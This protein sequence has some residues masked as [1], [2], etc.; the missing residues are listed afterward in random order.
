MRIVFALVCLLVGATALADVGIGVSATENDSTI[1]VPITASRLMFEPYV[2]YSD[3]DAVFNSS[4]PTSGQVEEEFEN[5]EVGVGIFRPLQ[6]RDR[7]TFYYGGRVAYGQQRYEST[8]VDLFSGTGSPDL[9]MQRTDLD[10]YSIIPSLGL[11]YSVI[12]RLSLGVEV[13]WYYSELDGQQFIDPTFGPTSDRNQEV[14][15]TGT[16]A[17]FIVRFFF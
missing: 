16:R 7:I 9:F 15:Q 1:Y 3:H 12:E 6:P 2:R 5:Y 17:R 10:G 13:G 8:S 4:T 14:T 11:T